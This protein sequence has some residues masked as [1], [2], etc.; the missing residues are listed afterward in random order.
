MRAPGPIWTGAGNLATTG[1]RSP[2]YPARSKLLYR[3][4]YPDPDSCCTDYISSL[5][6]AVF[7]PREF[8]LPIWSIETMIRKFT[9]YTVILRLTKIVR[10][11]ITFVS[12]NVILYKLYKCII[13][14][15]LLN[16]KYVHNVFTI[17]LPNFESLF[18]IS[19]WN[20]PTVHVCC[21]MLA[22]ATTKTFVSRI[23][24]R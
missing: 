5:I 15:I 16:W 10:S 11:R 20:G 18:K 22:R 14:F 3:L 21:F 19:S 13:L 7:A 8:G 1:I 4:S 9:E 6:P 2:D 12:R 17:L 24:I 23:H